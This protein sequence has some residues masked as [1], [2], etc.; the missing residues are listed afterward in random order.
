MSAARRESLDMLNDLLVDQA[1]VG[2][3]ADQQ[4]ELAMLFD[5]LEEHDELVF[6]QIAAAIHLGCEPEPEPMPD[7]LRATVEAQAR[8]WF[9]GNQPDLRLAGTDA[10]VHAAPASA[11]TQTPPSSFRIGPWLVAAAA[12]LI[13]AFAWWPNA[14]TTTVTPEPTIQEIVSAATDAESYEWSGLHDQDISGEIVWSPSLQ[15]GYFKVAGLPTNDPTVLQYQLWIFDG[16][17]PEPLNAVDG[18]V[19][20]IVNASN[21]TIITI[22]AKLEVFQPALFAITREK[23]GGVIK[24]NPELDPNSR[25]DAIASVS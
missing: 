4:R 17:R 14:S 25:I 11:G 16:M 3:N 8:D 1:T 5:E 10:D 21:E 2:L 22:D 20:D 13:A 24:H 6:E 7:H 23:P 9:A 18:G 12:I 19:F 15:K